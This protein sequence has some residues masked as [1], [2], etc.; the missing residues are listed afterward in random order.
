MAPSM[1]VLDVIAEETE[2]AEES[3]SLLME[4]KASSAP[5]RVSVAVRRV[6]LSDVEIAV[7]VRRCQMALGTAVEDVSAGRAI[8]Q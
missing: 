4:L 1:P 8:D 6:V 3:R 2:S 7:F 5:C